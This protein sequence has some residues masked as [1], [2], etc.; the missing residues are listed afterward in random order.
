MLRYPLWLR[1]A[2]QVAGAVHDIAIIVGAWLAY[3]ETP[4]TLASALGNY[5][6]V[7][8]VLLATGGLLGLSGLLF[9]SI[10]LEWAGCSATTAAKLTWAVAAFQPLSGVVGTDTLA[11]LLIAGAAT[12]MWRFFGLMVGYYLAPRED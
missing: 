6:I 11:C 12:T 7:W 8:C 2:I 1:R 3:Y 10:R 4:V 5:R 9:D